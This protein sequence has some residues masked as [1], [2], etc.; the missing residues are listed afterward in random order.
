MNQVA[1]GDGHGPG[2][3]ILLFPLIWAAVAVFG[4]ALLR[5]AGLPRGRR[6]VLPPR[7]GGPGAG[8]PGAGSPITL[9]GRRFAAGEIDE[10]EY[11]RRLSVLDEQFGRHAG[12]GRE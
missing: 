11:W 6:G 2:P 4:L 5:R 7:E 1:F 8:L 10:E 3:W 12:G 9:L